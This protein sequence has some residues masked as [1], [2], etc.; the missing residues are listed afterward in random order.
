PPPE[1]LQPPSP[2]PPA[3]PEDPP[4]D[5]EEPEEPEI[6]DYERARLE[7]IARNNARLQALGLLQVGTDIAADRAKQKQERQQDRE[8]KRL[9]RME[10]ENWGS[11]KSE[12]DPSKADAVDEE[13]EKEKMDERERLEEKRLS[14]LDFRRKVTRT[15]AVGASLKMQERRRELSD[16][17][18]K[19]K[20]PLLE[21]RAAHAKA[22]AAEARASC[23]PPA[24]ETKQLLLT[25]SNHLDNY[26]LAEY[27]YFLAKS[28]PLPPPPT[29]SASIRDPKTKSIAT[30]K[31]E[32]R[33]LTGLKPTFL[34][35]DPGTF[36]FTIHPRFSPPSARTMTRQVHD[37]KRY[38]QAGT[39]LLTYYQETAPGGRGGS[40]R[41]FTT[42]EVAYLR[43]RNW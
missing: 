41:P 42:A 3:A 7:R 1:Q 2:P 10:E 8:E 26:P 39:S 32:V 5:P 27:E 36:S 40:I 20:G 19:L 28:A 23:P 24:D 34:D 37:F 17:F 4:S 25:I 38:Y 30:L 29:L 13:R 35:R 9:R 6:G 18:Y 15:R 21:A 43:T 31:S 12:R 33:V 11:R 14:K 16:S 22:A